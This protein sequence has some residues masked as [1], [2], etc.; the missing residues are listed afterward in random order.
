MPRPSRMQKSLCREGKRRSAST[1]NTR[2][3]SCAS[4]IAKLVAMVVLPSPGCV[5]VMS[6]EPGG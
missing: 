3:P 4:E 2:W 5:L 6:K 1:S